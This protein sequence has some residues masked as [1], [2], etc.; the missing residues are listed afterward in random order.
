MDVNPFNVLGYHTTEQYAD[1]LDISVNDQ[2]E[3]MTLYVNLAKAL[4]YIPII[5]TIIGVAKLAFM[6][7]NKQMW[8]ENGDSF[9]RAFN[10]RTFIETLSLG[11]LFIIPDIVFTAL[12]TNAYNDDS[13]DEQYL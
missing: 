9:M 1:A 8:D 4:A 3:R 7:F 2:I 11:S 6:S 13:D 12:R 10:A 5:G